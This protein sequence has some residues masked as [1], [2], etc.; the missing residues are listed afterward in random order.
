MAELTVG[1]FEKLMEVLGLDERLDAARREVELWPTSVSEQATIELVRRV[2]H[3]HDYS[4]QRVT[5]ALMGRGGNDARGAG[6]AAALGCLVGIGLGLWLALWIINAWNMG[7]KD[8]PGVL[9]FLSFGGG[10]GGA[11]LGGWLAC[12]LT[13]LE[14]KE[15]MPGFLAWWLERHRMAV[16]AT[17]VGE[18]LLRPGG[19]RGDER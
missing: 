3:P 18:T 16:D 15:Q 11:I 5:N 14:I 4:V 12:W 8:G 7:T 13:A 17:R 10:I 6:G 19:A 1:Q 9:L 2:F